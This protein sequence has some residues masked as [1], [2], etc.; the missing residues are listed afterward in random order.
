MQ[1]S[2]SLVSS[3]FHL[4]TLPHLPLGSCSPLLSAVPQGHEPG[5]WPRLLWSKSLSRLSL[6]PLH[7]SLPHTPMASQNPPTLPPD[8]TATL[9]VFSYFLKHFEITTR[10][11]L[12]GYLPSFSGFFSEGH[13]LY[14]FWDNPAHFIDPLTISFHISHFF[15]YQFPSPLTI[16]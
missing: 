11:Y 6:P 2:Q 1:T 14:G 7:N 5:A 9:F 10:G 3:C 16:S 12:E 13:L 15:F 8:P 4:L